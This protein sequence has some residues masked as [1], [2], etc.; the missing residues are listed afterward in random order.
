MSS[1]TTATTIGK[2]A[3][4]AGVGV[5]TI[6][7][8]ERRG[9]IAQPPKPV[10]GGFRDYPAATLSQIRFIR[11]AQD[12]GFSL[13][14]ISDLMS[15]RADPKADCAQVQRRAEAKLAEV[16]DKVERLKGI[17]VALERLIEACP[18]KGSLGAC[19]I[20]EALESD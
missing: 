18:G 14:E 6:R 5:E 8:Y 15:L 1:Q 20:I 17:G 3:K 16:R 9:L 12:L 4:R 2:A 7:F 19:S 10:A 13:E 11:E